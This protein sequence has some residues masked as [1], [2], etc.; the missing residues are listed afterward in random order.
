MLLLVYGRNTGWM[1]YDCKKHT[2]YGAHEHLQEI[3]CGLLAAAQG[4]GVPVWGNVGQGPTPTA[5]RAVV[6]IMVR[7]DVQHDLSVV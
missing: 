4:L 3:T 2:S 6:M 1:S 7:K 5:R